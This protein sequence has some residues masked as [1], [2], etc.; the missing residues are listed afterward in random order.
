MTRDSSDKNFFRVETYVDITEL[1]GKFKFICHWTNPFK[2]FEWSNVPR[3]KFFLFS[4]SDDTFTSLQA[5]SNLNYLFSGFMDYFWSCELNI[6]NFGPANRKILPMEVILNE[7][8]PVPTRVVEGVLQPVAPTT[9]EQ[10][11]AKKNELKARGT[12]LMALPD[13]HQLKFNFYKDAKTLMESIEKRFGGNT[14]TKK[15]KKTLLKQQ[16]ENFIVSAATSVSSV[17][18]KMHV[19]SLPNVDSLSNAMAMLTMR[20]RRFVQKTGINLGANGPTFIGF[21]MS[22]VECY[23]C[24]RKGHFAREYSPTKPEQDLSYTN[25]PTAPII[26]DWVSNSEDES[27]TKAPQSVPSF[28][29]SSEQVKSSRH[30]VQHVETYIPPATSKS[31]SSK[32]AS[33]GKRRNIKACFVCKS[34]DHLIKDCDYHAKK[35]AQPTTRNHTHRGTHKNYVQMT[36]PNPQKHMVSVAVLTQS[37]P[38]SITAVRPVSAAVPQFKVTRPRHAKPIITKINS[39]IGRHITRSHSPKTSNSPPRVTVVKAAVGNPQHALKD[40]GEIDSGCSRH[41]IGNMSYLSDFEELNGGYVAFEGNPKGGKISGKGKIGTSKLD[42]EDVYFV[43]ELKFNIFS[44]SQMCDKKNCVL[45]TDTECLVLSLDF[46]LPDASQVLLRVPR[47]NNMHNVNLKNIVHFGDLTCLFAKATIDESNLWHRRL[48]HINF[49]TIN[50]LVKGNLVR[51]LPSKLFEN[52]NTCVA[53]KKGKQHRASFVIDDY[54]RFT[55]VF[56]LATKN[57]TS[58]I[59]KT[60]INGLKNQLSLKVKV[61]RSDNGTKFK[62]HDLNQFCRMKGIKREF[63]VPRNPQQNG[64][65]ERKNRTLIEAARTMLEDSFLPIPFW[66]EAVNT[67]CYV[68]NRVLVTKPHNKTPYELLHG[69]T[70]SIGFMRPFGCPVTILNTLDSLGKFKGKVDEGFLVGFSVNSK[71]FR[72]FNSRTRIVQETLHVNFLE[73]KP[74]IAG[75]EIDQQYVLFPVWS[76][77]S[78]NPQINDGDAAFDG[79]E[80]DFDAKKPKSKV[81]VSPSSS[82]QLRK[83]DDKTKKD[84]KRKSPVESFTRYRDLSV[85]FEDC[86]NNSINEVNAAEADFNNLET[87]ITVSPIPTT[88]VHKDPPVSQ[89]IGDLSSTT[90]TRSMT[91]VEPKRVHQALKDPSWIEAMQEELLQFKMQKEE[92]IDYEEVFTPVARIEAIILFLSY[93]SFMGFMVYQMDVESAFLYVTIE[94]E[95]YVCQHLGFEDPDHPEKVYKVV[96]ALYGLH[97]APKAWYETLANYLLQN[98]DIIFGATNKDLC[99]SFEKLMKDKFQ[100]SSMGEVTFFLGLQVKQKKDRIFI[101]QDKYVAE[102]LRKFRLTKRKLAST[103]IDTEKPLLKD[104]DGEDVDVHTYSLVRNVDSTTKF[105]MYPHFL[106]LII[107]KQVGDLSTHTTKY[108]SPALN[109]KV[110][111]NIR[112]VGKGFFGVETP[113]FEAMLVEQQGDEKEDADENIEEVNAGDAAEGDDSAAHGEVP[114][115]AKEQS[116]PSPIPPNP[117]PQPPQDI[118]STS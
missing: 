113:L 16:Y 54:S 68:Q 14:E 90:Q 9:T 103:P 6:S 55:W 62:N 19:S 89:I 65:A 30:S 58:P 98:D 100:I 115:V 27:E 76:S 11:L 60:S 52:D 118:P 85:E 21:D 72:V 28:V 56:F 112:R 83:Q 42:F 26:E 36:H 108:T 59:L 8:S 69:R 116:I 66:A 3:V 70:P 31:A 75:E 77:G 17:C 82:V 34:V 99:K 111:E 105:Y 37:K 67:T 71:A 110:F 74:N 93:S 102:I 101:S 12:R 43:K 87:S 41:I 46:K 57:E 50:K 88:R 51:G 4:K 10:K 48:G 97:Q 18:A 94:E 95:V 1:F 107:R 32:P 81:N 79:K 2:D 104:P 5:L 106:Q 47:E 49:K 45:F 53:C 33:S 96:K 35:M 7:D 91:R 117:P 25:R 86:F 80:P 22:K 20:A 39:P 64:I 24:H 84:A 38:V 61:I 78:T 23:N 114:T 13:K 73:N 40:N 92:G 63:S 15:V 29:Q 44:V 109:Q